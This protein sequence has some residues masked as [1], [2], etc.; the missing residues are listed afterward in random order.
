MK[1]RAATCVVLLAGLL[2]AGVDQSPGDKAREP[3]VCEVHDVAM[4]PRE[5]PYRHGMIPMHESMDRDGSWT[6]RMKRFPHPGD[7]IPATNIVLPGQEESGVDDV[8]PVCVAARLAR[9]GAS[10]GTSPETGKT[11]VSPEVIR[12]ARRELSRL[13]ER[14]RENRGA[15]SPPPASQLA[16]CLLSGLAE[17]GTELTTL[18]AEERM[19]LGVVEGGGQHGRVVAVTE[20]ARIVLQERSVQDKAG[21][22]LRKTATLYGMEGGRWVKQGTGAIAG[23][24]R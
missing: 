11:A 3:R 21:S 20:E 24:M 23:A 8:C 2:M 7:C 18:T 13:E 16:Y 1:M 9:E 10:A 6:L 5:L 12:E 17:Q 15:E 14:A 19:N 4:E 22:Y